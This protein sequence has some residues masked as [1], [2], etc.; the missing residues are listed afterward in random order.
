MS[1]VL[2]KAKL[3]GTEI[4]SDEELNE[5]KN[6]N[7]PNVCD[8]S[9]QGL[10]RKML[11]EYSYSTALLRLK[12]YYGVVRTSIDTVKCID[13][14]SPFYNKTA[15]IPVC[16]GKRYTVINDIQTPYETEVLHTN[17]YAEAVETA[18]MLHEQDPAAPIA[19]IDNAILNILV[20]EDIEYSKDPYVKLVWKYTYN[21]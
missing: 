15:V 14:K 3:L 19:V 18:D 11:E 17:D 13:I 1:V 10:V 8:I 9:L 7:Y 16:S 12:N 6:I 4:Y 20:V 2:L 5:L 21:Y